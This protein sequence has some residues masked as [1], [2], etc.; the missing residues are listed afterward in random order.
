MKLQRILG[1]LALLGASTFT[2]TIADAHE[3][4][5]PGMTVVHP[6]GEATVP[7]ATSAP[8]Y[9]TVDNVTKAD[10]I[11]KVVTP[12]AETVE[13][14]DAGPDSKPP[15]KSLV[16]KPGDTEFTAGKRHLLL[17]GL[18]M[19]LQWGRSYE[20]LLMFEKGGPLQVQVSIGAH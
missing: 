17:K 20:M 12:L 11:V 8:V 7:G 15:L 14:R 10:R 13:F 4:Y 5:A 6:W 2:A 3:Y 19:P 1:A 9:F 18:K 16:I